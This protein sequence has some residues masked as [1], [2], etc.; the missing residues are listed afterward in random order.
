MLEDVGLRLLVGASTGSAVLGHAQTRVFDDAG[1]DHNR[2]EDDGRDMVE[3]GKGDHAGH[4]AN[5][6]WAW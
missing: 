1:E 3:G 5:K 6:L 4:A 2:G